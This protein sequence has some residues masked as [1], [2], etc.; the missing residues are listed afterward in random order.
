MLTYTGSRNLF[1]TLS[2]NTTETNKVLGDTLINEKAREIISVKPWNFREKVSTKSTVASTQFHNLEPDFAKLIT[3]TVTIGSTT[4]TPRESKSLEHWN[5]LNQS[6][7][8]SNTP[9]WYYILAGRLGY[10]PRPSSATTDAI[11]DTYLRKHKDLTIADYTAGTITTTSTASGV[12]TVTGS[13][14]TWTS[15]MIGR[16]IRIDQPTGDNVWYEIA[17]VPTSTTLTLTLAYAGTAISA[18]TATYTIGQV[19]ILPED[20]QILPVYGAL[21]IYFTS[22]QPEAERAQLYKTLFNQGMLRMQN[23]LGSK[24]TSPTL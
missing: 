16:Y 23:E 8:T 20:Y 1:G 10:Y 5:R 12:T 11:T 13:G 15:G 24:S 7:S 19:S 17:T 9:E 14:V 21:E 3:T 6:V 2:S 4:Y 18:A 22:V